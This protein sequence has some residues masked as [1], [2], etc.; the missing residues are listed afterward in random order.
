M[1]TILALLIFITLIFACQSEN[2]SSK[3]NETH[4]ENK[5]TLS[6]QGITG[7]GDEVKRIELNEGLAIFKSEYNN[8]RN[9]IVVLKDIDGTII[10]LLVNTIDSY[11]GSKSVKIFKYGSYLLQVTSHGNWKIEI[12]N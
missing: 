5:K 10:E 11:S 4:T 6:I 3:Q 2:K 1:K 12:E 8:K 7:K 9:S